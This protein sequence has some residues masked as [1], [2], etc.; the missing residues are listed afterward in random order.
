M[1]EYEPSLVTRYILDLC[2]DFNR[3][4]HDC[5]IINAE[6]E[7][8]RAMRLALT[9]AVNSVLGRALSLICIKKAEKI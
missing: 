3:F 8:T 1:H 5:P 9:V 6:D 7:K 4:Y 2:A